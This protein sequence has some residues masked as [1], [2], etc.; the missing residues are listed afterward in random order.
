MRGHIA[1]KGEATSIRVIVD[2]W[3]DGRKES[4]AERFFFL[5]LD[6]GFNN[7]LHAL[8]S[9]LR[10]LYVCVCNLSRFYISEVWVKRCRIALGKLFF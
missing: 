1:V 3:M 4:K 6:I 2:G 5:F 7:A 10:S 8:Q 9:L